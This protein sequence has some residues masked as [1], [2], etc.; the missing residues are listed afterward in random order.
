MPS[1]MSELWA[2]I[3]GLFVSYISSILAKLLPIPDDLKFRLSYESKKILKWIRNVPIRITY[4]LKSQNLEI[5]REDF[6]ERIKDRLIQ[7]N[8][9]YSDLIGDTIIFHFTMGKT[10]AELR[11]T[12]SYFDIQETP[13]VES[14]LMIS[15]I[16][17]DLLVDQC[18]YRQFDGHMVDLLQ[19]KDQLQSIL[20]DI[21]GLWASES[22]SCELQKMYKFIG[23]LSGFR[24]ST[25]TGKIGDQRIDLSEKGLV[26]YGTVEQT[27][28]D[29]LKKIITFYY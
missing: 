11:L 25:L 18:K 6:L 23:I 9:H 15:S 3:L 1:I 24:L 21:L 12:P 22:L 26:I 28:L 5:K 27:L 17:A 20:I 29:A 2:F 14:E 4:T 13:E 19:I 7:N 8:F 16:Q 10:E